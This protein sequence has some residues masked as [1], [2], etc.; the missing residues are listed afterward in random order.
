MVARFGRVADSPDPAARLADVDREI[1]A[2][3][4]ALAAA[5]ARIAQLTGEP[6]LLGQPPDRIARERDAWRARH[7]ADRQQRPPAPPRPPDPFVLERAR[8]PRRS[9][10]SIGR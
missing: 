8:S 6:A 10:P 4:T 7:T 3:R 1:T 5:Q 2:A 9:G